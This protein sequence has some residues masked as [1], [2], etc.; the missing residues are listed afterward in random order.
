MVKQF[1]KCH[2]IRRRF[3]MKKFAIKKRSSTGVSSFKISTNLKLISNT[4]AFIPLP[5]NL[6]RLLLLLF[7]KP[8][9]SI[10]PCYYIHC[11]PLLYEIGWDPFNDDGYQKKEPV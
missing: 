4:I 7:F 6:E 5:I 11:L 9:Q 2:G 3:E 8:D 10:V 1:I